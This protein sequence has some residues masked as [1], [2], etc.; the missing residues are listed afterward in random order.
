MVQSVNYGFE[1][2]LTVISWISG[3]GT[4]LYDLK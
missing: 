4:V 2:V 3:G 1:P